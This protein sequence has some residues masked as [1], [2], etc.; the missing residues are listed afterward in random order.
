MVS[1]L[2]KFYVYRH[3]YQHSYIVLHKNIFTFLNVEKQC[4]DFAIVL[5][6]VKII[7]SIFVSSGQKI[8]ISLYCSNNVRTSVAPNI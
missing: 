3:C 5:D 2:Y 7:F 1:A 4:S 6:T 8:S